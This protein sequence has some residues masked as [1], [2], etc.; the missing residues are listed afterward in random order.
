VLNFDFLPPNE[1]DLFIWDGSQTVKIFK[2]EGALYFTLSTLVFLQPGQY[3][4]EINVYPDLV[5]GYTEA[6]GKIF[7]D[8]PLSGEIQFV[9]DVPVTTWILPHIGRRSTYGHSFTVEIGRMVKVG[10][11]IRGRWA[12]ENNGWFMDD[13]SLTQLP[14]SGL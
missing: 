3:Q 7:A 6:G 4:F 11:A 5:V 2:G 13:W 1:H 9:V 14:D 10:L 12:I 8:D